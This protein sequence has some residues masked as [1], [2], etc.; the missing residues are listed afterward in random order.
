[1]MNMIRVKVG[2]DPIV[3]TGRSGT[4][5]FKTA[6]QRKWCKYPM[7]EAPDALSEEGSHK[8]YNQDS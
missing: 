8:E 2:M 6:P 4:Q 3:H 7:G 5:L 1:M